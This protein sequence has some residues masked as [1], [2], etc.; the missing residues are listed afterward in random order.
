MCDAFHWDLQLPTAETY[1]ER[2]E[3]CRMLAKFC[4]EHLRESYLQL[5]A[6]YDQLAREAQP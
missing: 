1:S 5:A 6:A 2:A 3:E 4:P